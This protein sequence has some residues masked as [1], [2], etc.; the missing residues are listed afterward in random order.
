MDNISAIPQQPQLGGLARF[1][2]M[3][4]QERPEFLP[5][6][7]DVMGLIRQ[8]ALPSASTVE[9]LS[10]GNL[11]FTMPPA[12]TGA[13][14]PQ[15]KTGRKPEVAD[16]VGMLGGV[17]GAGAVADVGTKLSNE[18]ADVLVRAITRN[19][20]ATAPQVLEAAGQITPLSRIVN[21][22]VAKSL[23]MP[24]NFP[25]DDVFANA[26]KN[27]P[28]AQITNEGLL[29]RVQRNQKPEQAG[30]ESVRTGVFY[31]PEGS[32]QARYYSS[33]KIGYGGTEKIT[34]ETLYKNPLFVKGATGGKAPEA[35]YDQ[36]MGKDAYKN[37]RS[38]VL[39]SYQYNA[40]QSQ[41]IEAIQGILEKYN[42]IDSDDAYNMAYNIVTNSKQG[43][44]LPYAVQEN[45]VANAVRNAGYDSVLGYSQK[46]SGDKFIS[47]IFDVREATYPT[48]QGGFTLMPEFEDLLKKRSLLD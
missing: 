26:V 32:E 5:R 11:P 33:G 30:E 14:I 2:R 8:L 6:Q 46:K 17:P 25:K 34:G 29:M 20:Q 22:E 47:E 1:L 44:T 38:A 3:L 31:L 41:K 4:E 37:M 42:K 9:N 28:G 7:L 27:T 18:A 35:A 15:V 24:V 48:K 10:Y 16:L 45:I 43:N 36:I 12:G 23:Q 40:N 21:P 19:P 39:N 13:A